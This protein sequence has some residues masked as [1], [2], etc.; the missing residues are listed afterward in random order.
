MATLDF[1]TKP[2]ALVILMHYS[3]KAAILCIQNILEV[4]LED[5][6]I[7]KMESEEGVNFDVIVGIPL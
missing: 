7:L 5:I 6:G 4:L 1:T 3:R 2:L